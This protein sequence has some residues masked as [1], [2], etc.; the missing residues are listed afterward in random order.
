MA[1][2]DAVW[3]VS[4]LAFCGEGYTLLVIRLIGS[5]NGRK[6]VNGYHNNMLRMPGLERY[7]GFMRLR[8]KNNA[9]TVGLTESADLKPWTKAIEVLRGDAQNQAY[10]MAVF[11]YADIYLGLVA[12]FCIREDR[13]HTELAW[14]PDTVTWHRIQPGTPI[15]GNSPNEGDYDWGCVYPAATPVVR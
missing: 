13:V 4:C 2:A 9:R 1:G 3:F 12:I 11:R 14:S 10:S 5:L 15:I 6:T 7:V 8:D